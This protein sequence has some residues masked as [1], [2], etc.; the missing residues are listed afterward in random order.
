[1]RNLAVAEIAQEGRDL[2]GM[3]WV[4]FRLYRHAQA[5]G[6]RRGAYINT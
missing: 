1:L 6:T 4:D 5:L 2:S 3:G